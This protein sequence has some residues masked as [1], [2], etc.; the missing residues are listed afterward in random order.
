MGILA[1]IS[2]TGYTNIRGA[3]ELS[4][5]YDELISEMRKLQSKSQN[6]NPS[7][8]KCYGMQFVTKGLD[9]EPQINYV[10]TNYLN[11]VQKCNE[12]QTLVTGQYYEKSLQIKKIATESGS[13]SS[14]ITIYFYPPKGEILIPSSGEAELHLELSIK[15]KENTQEIVINKVNGSIQKRTKVEIAPTP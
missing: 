15:D 14:D 3:A 9:R 10:E 7:E 2:L 4:L 11:P 1:V 12:L 6:L 5:Q 8:P 13:Q